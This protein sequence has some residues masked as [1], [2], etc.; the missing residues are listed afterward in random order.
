M[1]R[2]IFLEIAWQN[3][4]S[5]IGLSLLDFKQLLVDS[6]SI[7]QCEVV[8]PEVEGGGVDDEEENDDHHYHCA[9]VPWEPEIH[10]G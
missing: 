2:Q 8:A 6:G 1:L 5:K 7:V 4:L 3:W 9:G 10:I